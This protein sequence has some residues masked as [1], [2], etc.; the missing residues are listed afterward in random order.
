MNPSK[1]HNNWL[2]VGEIINLIENPIASYADQV[3]KEFHAKLSHNLV[4]FGKCTTPGDCL[5]KKKPHDLCHSCNEWY[6]E[7]ASSHRNT[8]KSQIKWRQNCDTSKWPDDAWEVAKFFMSTLGDNKT[9]V[10]DADSTDLSSLLNVLEWISDA[11]FDGA[12]RVDLNLV[13]DLRS[14]VRNGWAH[15]PKQ[16]ITDQ[17][18]NNAFQISIEFLDD[19]NKVASSKEVKKCI[20]DIQLLQANGLTNVIEAELN[21]L[22]F[23]APR[24]VLRRH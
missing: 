16:E 1:N 3:V 11:A 14:K 17:Q 20:E 15:A 18:L 21:N 19:L 4:R 24:I 9:S 22:P 5:K 13:G 23:A 2:T 10:K 6:K 12:R 8:N 7:L